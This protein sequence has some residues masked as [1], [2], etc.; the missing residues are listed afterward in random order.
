MKYSTIFFKVLLP[1]I[2]CVLIT[3]FA[4]GGLLFGPLLFGLIVGLVNW[5]LH[6]Y[7]PFFGC[8]FSIILSYIVFA[9]GWFGLDFWKHIIEYILDDIFFKNNISSSDLAFLITT[10]VIAPLLIYLLYKI[11]FKIPMGKFTLL[12]IISSIFILI[13]ISV[14]LT[15]DKKY[16]IISNFNVW[17][18]INWQLIVMLS[19]QFMINQKNILKS[20]K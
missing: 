20:E 11:L 9:I 15:D 5:N 3:Y 2:L 6:K 19:L 16:H 10:F 18:V 7:D 13:F 8:L 17:Q 1:T 12:I 14:L 4:G